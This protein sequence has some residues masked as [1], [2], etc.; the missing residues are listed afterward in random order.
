[1]ELVPYGVLFVG[2][3]RRS[4][5][6]MLDIIP[7]AV[8]SRHPPAGGV[9]LKYQAQ[10]FELPNLVAYSRRTHYKTRAPKYRLRSDGMSSGHILLDHCA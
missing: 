9:Q 2:G 10:I 7:I 8:G 5:E 6:K 1:M 4:R 3:E